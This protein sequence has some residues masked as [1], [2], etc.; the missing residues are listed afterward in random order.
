MTTKLE[1]KNNPLVVFFPFWLQR[2]KILCVWF[3]TSTLFI[4]LF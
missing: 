4:C 2:T 1:Q 3:G